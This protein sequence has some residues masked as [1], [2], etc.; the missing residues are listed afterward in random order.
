MY[1]DCIF[2]CAVV[3]WLDCVCVGAIGTMYAVNYIYLGEMLDYSKDFSEDSILNGNF[4]SL[5]F[6][7]SYVTR[8]Y[9]VHDSLY[10]YCFEEML[11]VLKISRPDGTLM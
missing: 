4:I 8:V 2:Q 10:Y 5:G 9:H 7:F 3:L 6:S 11:N 1:S